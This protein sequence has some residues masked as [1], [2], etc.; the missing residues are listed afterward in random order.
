MRG[1]SERQQVDYVHITKVVAGRHHG[2]YER[3]RR[4]RVWLRLYG[5]AKLQNF[6]QIEDYRFL[7]TRVRGK[8]H[9]ARQELYPSLF[10]FSLAS[11]STIGGCAS[12]SDGFDLFKCSKESASRHTPPERI[13]GGPCIAC[14][15]RTFDLIAKGLPLE[16]YIDLKSRRPA[17]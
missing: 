4:G 11:S 8:Y 13:N 5:G 7:A 9:R 2:I 14:N 17:S 10:R 6:E 15:K 1:L 16:S 3:Q 12:L